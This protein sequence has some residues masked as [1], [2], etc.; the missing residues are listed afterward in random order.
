VRRK[1]KPKPVD[2]E[3]EEDRDCHLWIQ[4]GVLSHPEMTTAN[5]LAHVLPGSQHHRHMW[6]PLSPAVKWSH[7]FET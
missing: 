1:V 2:E 7:I 6:I 3:D 4:Q 5:A